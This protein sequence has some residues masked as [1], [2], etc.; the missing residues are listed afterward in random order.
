MRNMAYPTRRRALAALAGGAAAA[1]AAAASAQTRPGGPITWRLQ[2]HHPANSRIGESSDMFARDVEKLS[3]GRMKITKHHSG[4]LIPNADIFKGASTGIFEMGWSDPGYHVGFM[5]EAAIGTAPF[6]FQNIMDAFELYY[7]RGVLDFFRESYAPHGVHLVSMMPAYV[8]PLLSKRPIRRVSDFK[9]LKVRTIGARQT[10]MIQLG[11]A[12][13]GI[14]LPEVYGALA[15]GTIDAATNGPEESFADFSWHEVA[16]FI[17]YPALSS[18]PLPVNDIYVNAK[19]WSSLPD[20]LKAI[21]E[22]AGDLNF[23]RFAYHFRYGDF[24]VRDKY[25]KA[26]ITRIHLP[27]EDNAALAAAASVVWTEIAKKSPRGREIV[28]RFT[29]YMRA[30]AYTDYDVNKAAPT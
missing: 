11:A 19:A 22:Y 16:K 6:M 5:P 12:P 24:K 8:I 13:V 30:M 1:S 18:Y 9:G 10:M 3:G 25:D 26:G 14:P 28:K 17:I 15:S 23:S 27:S 29:D 7:Y 21:V 20:D 2:T 4:A